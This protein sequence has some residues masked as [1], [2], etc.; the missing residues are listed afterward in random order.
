MAESAQPLDDGQQI[1]DVTPTPTP[2]PVSGVIQS[3]R[4]P[5][6]V[7]ISNDTQDLLGDALDELGIQPS[8]DAVV[9]NLDAARA[10]MLAKELAAKNKLKPANEV[11]ASLEKPSFDQNPTPEVP[12]DISAAE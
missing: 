3:V 9:V 10:A 5:K 12:G 6:V 8:N 2:T 11:K 4:P 7:D 1:L